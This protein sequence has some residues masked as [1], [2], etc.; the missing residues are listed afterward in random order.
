MHL[1]SLK[2][3]TMRFGGITAVDAVDLEVEKDQIFSIIGPNGAGKTTVFN[4]ITGIYEPTEGEVHFEDEPLV[5]P[6]S[7]RAVLLSI[8]VGLLTAVLFAVLA[9]NI[10]A[11]WQSAIRDVESTRQERISLYIG[12]LLAVDRTLPREELDAR[13]KSEIHRRAAAKT[14]QELRDWPFPLQ[15]LAFFAGQLGGEIAVEQWEAIAPKVDLDLIFQ[16]AKLIPVPAIKEHLE[17]ALPFSW[18]EARSATRNH[19]AERL[20]RAWLGFALGFLLGTAGMLVS[21]KRARHA[22]DIISQSGIARTFQN[23]RLFQSMTVIENVLIGLTRGMSSHP[24]AGAFNLPAHR[25]EEAEAERKA[26]ELLAFIGLAGKHNELAKNLPYGDQRR[27]EIARALATNPKLL[28]LDEPAAGMNPSETADL[29]ELIR[30][31]RD[32][33][34]TV[35]LIEHHMSLVMGI[36]DRVAVLNFGKKIAEGTPAEVSNNPQVIEAYLGKE[37]VT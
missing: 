11:L 2:K 24:I 25:R 33:G 17:A 28:L 19:F 37:D 15:V 9:V 35:L 18:S 16:G 8:G 5:K 21:W 29:M 13:I 26:G 32:R 10:E 14:T 4:A 12:A 30:R 36:S 27:L 20:D 31:I 23:I 6:V 22:P 34:I 3:L 7:A 1:L